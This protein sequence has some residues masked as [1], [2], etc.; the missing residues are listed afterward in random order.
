MATHLALSTST[1]AWAYQNQ[2]ERSRDLNHPDLA[3]HQQSFESSQLNPHTAG[4]PGGV[5]PSDRPFANSWFTPRTECQVMSEREQSKLYIRQT[6]RS[7]EHR[8]KEHQFAIWNEDW[9]DSAL[10]EHMYVCI[11]LSRWRRRGVR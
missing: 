10:G 7:L 11:Y 8:L 4:H 5:L 3:L 1:L 2:T 9:A 6:G